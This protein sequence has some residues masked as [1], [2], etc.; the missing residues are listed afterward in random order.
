MRYKGNKRNI[1]DGFDQLGMYYENSVSSKKHEEFFKDV[2]EIMERGVQGAVFM[3]LDKNNKLQVIPLDGNDPVL[4]AGII[5]LGK[6][7]YAFDVLGDE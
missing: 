6:D 4:N 5:S 2:H 3:S 1:N 7:Y